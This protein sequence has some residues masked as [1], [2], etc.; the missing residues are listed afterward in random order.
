MTAAAQLRVYVPAED[1]SE[2][3]LRMPEASDDSPATWRLGPFGI[4]TESLQDD[5]VVVHHDGE[6]FICPRLPKLRMLEGVLAFHNAFGDIGADKIV[7]EAVAVRAAVELEAIRMDEGEAR[8]HILT[9]QWHVPLRW[10]LLFDPSERSFRED[11]SGVALRYR[12][13]RR[14]ASRRLRRAIRAL[15]SVGMESTTEDME[16]LLDWML[17][18]P[19]NRLVELDYDGVV[20]L[21]EAEEL[22]EDQSCELLWKAVEALEETDFDG[23]RRWYEE[24]AIRWADAMLLAYA[25]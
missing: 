2:D 13:R 17:E 16:H 3:W 21:F 5:V 24:T 11:E 12:T 23:A 22:A 14:E 25:N 9:S 1:A 4:T 6:R 15:R 10:F 8:S 20:G 19:P 7:P 18:F